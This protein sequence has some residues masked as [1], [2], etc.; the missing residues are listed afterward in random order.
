MTQHFEIPRLRELARH[1]VPHLLEATF[2]PLV[3]FLVLLRV[4]GV[5]GAVLVGMVWT[6]GAVIRRLLTGR[7]VPGILMLSAVTITARTAVSFATHSVV[8][9]FL[10]PTLG[11]VLIAC[12]FLVSVPLGQPLAQRLARDFVPLPAWLLAEDHI[13]KFFKRVSLLW[14]F[15]GLANASIALWLLFS[16]SIGTFYVARTGASWVL[17]GSA[18]GIS[19]WWFHRLMAEHGHRQPAMVP[20]TARR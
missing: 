5:W 20:V 9:Y 10:Q 19:T 6:Y 16:Q 11:Q 3:L 18:I 13:G 2:I 8:V 12:A 4:T 17:T 14:A 1:A 7:R 15:V